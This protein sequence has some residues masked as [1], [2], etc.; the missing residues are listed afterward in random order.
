[1]LGAFLKI[2]VDPLSKRLC[3]TYIE[4]IVE[5][6]ILAATTPGIKH[7]VFNVANGKDNTVL[8]LVDSLNEII[9]KN[10][11]P[12]F[13]PIRPGDVFK[14]LADIT[15]IKTILGFRPKVNF[16]TGLKKT[17]KWFS[18]EKSDVTVLQ[19]QK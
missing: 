11:K 15:K 12:E 7:E 17:V 14:T 8:Q 18:K 5:A 10:I 16:E 3:F 1:M 13:L 6:N 2:T 19:Y 9:G 4:N